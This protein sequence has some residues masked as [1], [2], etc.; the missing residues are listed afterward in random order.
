MR[1]LG[2]DFGRKRIGLAVGVTEAGIASPRMR[3]EATGTLERDAAA[4]A[5]KAK[6]EE[7]DAVVVGVP[8][9]DNPPDGGRQQR[10]CRMLAESLESRG[11]KVYTV[12]EAMT[13][14]EAESLLRD[15]GL[16]AAKRGARRDGEAAARILERFMEEF[17]SRGEGE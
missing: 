2:V 3:L 14:V 13:T 16:S 11:L 7:A 4:I 17:A 10:I 5:A 1:L 15:A 6:S 8:L 9:L 12:D